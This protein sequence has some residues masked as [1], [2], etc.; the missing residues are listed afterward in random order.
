MRGNDAAQ[1]AAL[2][3]QLASERAER[4]RLEAQLRNLADHDPVTDLLNRRS[5]EHEIEDHLAGCARYGAEGAL[6]LVGLDGLDAIARAARPNEVDELLAA[7]AEAVA[8]RLRGNDVAG[9]WEPDELAVLL[10]RAAEEQVVAVAAAMVKL[11]AEAATPRVPAGSLAASVGVALIGSPPDDPL[12]LVD[13]AC[14]ALAAAR[15]RGGGGWVV[16][17][18]E[19]TA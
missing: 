14:R 15:S 10:P 12:L 16:A 18:W 2:R 3:W 13:R 6:L 17:G 19:A 4:R 11:V 1:L 8:G 5:L 9:R 7:L